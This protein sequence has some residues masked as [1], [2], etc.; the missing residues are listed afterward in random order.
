MAIHTFMLSQT[1]TKKQYYYALN[2]KVFSWKPIRDR[3]HEILYYYSDKLKEKGFLLFQIWKFYDVKDKHIDTNI[4]SYYFITITI[5]ASIILGGNGNESVKIIHLNHNF[6][7]ILK[8]QLRRISSIFDYY[9]VKLRRIDF[10][11][12]IP[13]PFVREYLHLLEYSYP[14]PRYEKLPPIKE[15]DDLI[16][17]MTLLEE[18][19]N[20][21][22]NEKSLFYTNN[23]LNINIYHKYS[24]LIRS[25]CIATDRDNY[26]RIELQIKKPKLYSLMK[27]YNISNRT[28][29]DFLNCQNIEKLEYNL[30]T[31]YLSVLTGSGTYVS[32]NYAKDVIENA[33]LTAHRK[34]IMMEL[35][36]DI[37]KHHGISAFFNFIQNNKNSKYGSLNNI[38]QYLTEINKLDINPVILPIRCN[39]MTRELEINNYKITKYLPHLVTYL[40]NL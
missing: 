11:L 15:C 31:Y 9:V 4:N 6:E 25:G 27:K 30:F 28:I 3:K 29:T 33:N 21:F 32:F 26:L 18:H 1:L 40:N 34:R 17:Q 22:N 24:Q 12:D 38:K 37:T 36:A 8:K 35:L 19:N 10:A 2:E 5:N 39:S 20:I 7:D 14:L 16:E 13:T 23:S